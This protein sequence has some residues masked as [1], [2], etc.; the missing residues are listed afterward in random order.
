MSSLLAHPI[1]FD[2]LALDALPREGREHPELRPGIHLRLLPSPLVGLPL[3]PFRLARADPHIWRN[4]VLRW[5]GRDG[6]HAAPNDLDAAEGELI[7]RIGSPPN[8]A[9]AL[10]VEIRPDDDARIEEVALIGPAEDPTGSGR[11]LARRVAPPFLVGGSMVWW[12]RIRGRGRVPDPI[13]WI[14]PEIGDLWRP[15]REQRSEA[16]LSL[17]LDNPTGWYSAPTGEAPAMRRVVEDRLRSFGPP[18]VMDP[19]FAELPEKAEIARLEA[20]APEVRRWLMRALESRPRE[21]V[22]EEDKVRLRPTDALLMQALDPMLARFLG[23][24]ARLDD[25]PSPD[26]VPALWAACGVFALDARELVPLG[27]A[28]VLPDADA[29]EMQLLDVLKATTPGLEERVRDLEGLGLVVR[30]LLAP[31]VAVPPPEPPEAPLL[32]EGEGA[33]MPRGQPGN[34]E[35]HYRREVLVRDMPF[36]AL[37]AVSR[38]EAGGVWSPSH[39]LVARSDWDGPDRFACRLPGDLPP[40]LLLTQPASTRIM[41][42]SELIP[43]PVPQPHRVCLG[44]LF[45]RY[46]STSVIRIAAP[47]RPAPPAPVPQL[48]LLPNRRAAGEADAPFGSLRIVVPVPPMEELPAGARP[49]TRI[50]WRIGA[51]GAQTAP[52]ARAEWRKTVP[53]PVSLPPAGTAEIEVSFV[54]LD[55]DD[56]RSEAAAQILRLA[57]PRPPPVVRAGPGIIWTGRPGADPEVELKLAWTA[58]PGQRFASWVADA[59]ALTGDGAPRA[60]ALTAQAAFERPIGAAERKLFRPLVPVPV[61]ADAGGK[62]LLDARL[63]RSLTGVQLVCLVPLSAQGVEGEFGTGGIVPVA[64]PSASGPLAPRLSLLEVE[65]VTGAARFEIVATGIDWEMLRLAEPGLFDQDGPGRKLRW[66]LRRAGGRDAEPLYA[67]VRLEGDLAIDLTDPTQPRAVAEVADANG[68][69][70]ALLP[71]VA[72]TYWAEVRLPPERR[73]PSGVMPAPG[74]VQPLEDWQKEDLPGRFSPPSLPV[75]AMRVPPDAPE[76]APEWLRAQLLAA[77]T[78][79]GQVVLDIA[80]EDGPVLHPR[81]TGSYLLRLWL[82]LG[83]GGALVRATAADLE[84]VQGALAWTSAPMPRPADGGISVHAALIDPIGRIGPVLELHAAE[85]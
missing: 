53:I 46:G 60:R 45:G 69:D 28:R 85:G 52:L 12:L 62:V 51:E 55:A 77:P 33:W 14:T 41:V 76:L 78:D 56:V 22:R 38:E 1:L 42:E 54:F 3:A 64:V 67:R 24:M 7:V 10:A 82:P 6:R 66:R 30:A 35:E 84:L 31:A 4:P 48:R 47:P 80:V 26:F 9:R 61:E 81:A 20:M 79:A 13:V 23:L 11:L 15:M 58:Q 71:F 18:D 50:E 43:A 72:Y 59:A 63:P 65:P 5:T 70:G 39:T 32:E 8:D 34:A 2:A 40:R 21:E 37:L 68:G 83:E 44:D 25:Q 17:P 36:A 27:L 49:V 16:W 19:P 57:D 29:E 73:L 74:A 75:T